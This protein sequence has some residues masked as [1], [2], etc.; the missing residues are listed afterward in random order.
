MSTETTFSTMTDEQEMAD[1]ILCLSESLSK[2]LQTEN[3]R[4]KTITLKLKTS[5]FQIITRSRTSD[6]YICKAVQINSVA[7]SVS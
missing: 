6:S 5:E 4:G 7:Q 3:L 2:D 1:K